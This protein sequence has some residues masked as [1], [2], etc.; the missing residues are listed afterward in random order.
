VNEKKRT[1]RFQSGGE[2]CSVDPTT[3]Q[4]DDREMHAGILEPIEGPLG[5]I[6]AA[7]RRIWADLAKRGEAAPPPP[8]KA[9][10]VACAER[11]D[12]SDA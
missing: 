5:D 12:R 8:D 6:G 10:I 3:G 7:Q 1:K 2:F 9:L 4:I 11:V